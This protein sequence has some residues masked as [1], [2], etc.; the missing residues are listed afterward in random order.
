MISA[1]VAA[2][3]LTGLSWL[4]VSAL[5]HMDSPAAQ[6]LRVA[7]Q[8]E[9]EDQVC[10]GY[11]GPRCV[12]D[13]REQAKV[14]REFAAEQ[15][16]RVA[17]LH[18]LE[19]RTLGAI[20]NL[21]AAEKILRSESIN[22]NG[23]LLGG[24]QDLI[25]LLLEPI[26][27]RPLTTREEDLAR[28]NSL[29]RAAYTVDLVDGRLDESAGRKNLLATIATQRQQ[30]HG[31][32][33]RLGNLAR[34]DRGYEIDEAFVDR[35]AL[36]AEVFNEDPYGTGGE[37]AG[38][39]LSAGE[40]ETT[41]A[42][43]AG[44]ARHRAD[45]LA[46]MVFEPENATWQG[47]F[48]ESYAQYEAIQKPSVRYRSPINDTQRWQ[49]FG[50]LLFGLAAFCLVVAGPVVTA[51]HTAREREAGTLPVLRMTG[52]S[53]D[54]LAL[55][56]VV[57][58][59]VFPL[60]A[61][62]LLLSLSLLALGITA[63]FSALLLPLVV[64]AGLTAIT[65]L[66]AIGLGDA[67]GH[68]VNAL[69]VGALLALVIVGPGLL[70][71]ILVTSGMAGAGLLLGPLP[72]VLT[73]AA[74]LSGVPGTSEL[75]FAS[76]GS[77]AD[78][79]LGVTL[80]SY[81]LLTQALLGGI[82][83]LS[84]RR[85]VE[86]AWAPLFR[87]L[88]GV[89]LALASVGCSALTLLDLSNRVNTQSFDN[90][91]LLTFL[92]SAFL[93]PLL[94][95]LLVASLRRPPRATAVADHAETRRAFWRFQLLLATTVGAVAFA[96]TVVM[97]QTGLSAEASEVMWATL[98]QIVLVAET[99]VA[100]LLLA[101][102]KRDGKH[103]VFMI[104]G[105]VLILQIALAVVIYHLEV[106]HVAITHTAGSPFLLGMDASPYWITFMIL[107]W[108]A[109]LGMI[110]AALLRERDLSKAREEAALEEEQAGDET[111]HR[112]RWLH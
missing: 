80:L 95:W 73:A 93:L 79:T 17:V 39:I 23:D 10:G 47:A 77:G 56:M 102:R 14:D 91:N 27:L 51:T 49:L 76:V 94:G 88:E 107:L 53:A 36:W 42:S 37:L 74:T 101:S 9:T 59:N 69:L 103:R 55:A 32:L 46:K 110:I 72:A 96:Y 89:A 52:L 105:A 104:G 62:G 45:E 71:T 20:E 97:E 44:L 111:E 5:T 4:A 19:S 84:W 28:V 108:G 61:G 1:F 11:D 54:D 25:K 13:D 3:L 98:T 67:L 109:G 22:L 82:C 85:R 75:V 87:P 16:L 68:R 41:T 86:Q 50:T 81:A 100:M 38:W 65:H 34:R 48:T 58:P 24:R 57:G 63:G 30:L 31:Y 70:G 21:N 83:L 8:L 12:Y 106:D 29:Q 99:A 64:L 35:H 33:Q 78:P 26:D 2:L 43:L 18:E 6:E 7:L 90:L 112:G 66:T 92:A 15:R 40:L 60:V